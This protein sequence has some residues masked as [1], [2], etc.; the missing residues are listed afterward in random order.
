MGQKT[1]FIIL[2]QNFW[3]QRPKTTAVL[4]SSSLITTSGHLGIGS[5]SLLSNYDNSDT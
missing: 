4:S 3:S 2:D 1:V 5:R